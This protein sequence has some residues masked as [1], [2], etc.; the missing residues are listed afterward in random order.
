MAN[1]RR[2]EYRSAS[3]HAAAFYSK[4]RSFLKLMQVNGRF[5]CSEEAAVNVH[6]IV[7]GEELRKGQEVL[8]C[9]YLVI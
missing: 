2:P 7:Q 5:S 6:Y 9:F 4:S 1:L 8:D 3:H